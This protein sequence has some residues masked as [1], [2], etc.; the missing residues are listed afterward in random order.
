MRRLELS[1]TPNMILPQ[2]FV[3]LKSLQH[4]QIKKFNTIA[5]PDA[6][7]SGDSAICDYIQTPKLD[8]VK[9]INWVVLSCRKFDH[10]SSCVRHGV[11]GIS[12]EGRHLLLDDITVTTYSLVEWHVGWNTITIDVEDGSQPTFQIGGS[13]KAVVGTAVTAAA[14]ATATAAVVM[15]VVLLLLLGLMLALATL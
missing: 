3:H 4:F 14:A 12:L 15:M 1:T 11:E 6:A 8:W 10:Y 13:K 5:D 2:A 9:F 7:S